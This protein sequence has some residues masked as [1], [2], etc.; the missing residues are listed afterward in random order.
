MSYRERVI[1][2]QIHHYMYGS[3]LEPPPGALPS[4]RKALQGVGEELVDLSELEK[5][6][7]TST[8]VSFNDLT[9]YRIGGGTCLGR[10]SHMFATHE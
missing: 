9:I 1:Y 2:N 4:K 5:L 7:P 10:T 3:H 6:A 8:T